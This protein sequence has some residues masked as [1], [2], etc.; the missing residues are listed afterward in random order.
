MTTKTELSRIELAEEPRRRRD[1]PTTPELETLFMQVVVHCTKREM[2]IFQWCIGRAADGGKALAE[3]FL[4]P[5]G[6][7]PRGGV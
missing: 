1:R 5:T 6:E 4:N 2:A 3:L 7:V